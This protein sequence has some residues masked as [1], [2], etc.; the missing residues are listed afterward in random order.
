VPA[1]LVIRAIKREW[2]AGL[3]ARARAQ[4]TDPAFGPDGSLYV[5][6]HAAPFFGGLGSIVRIAPG[7]TRPMVA[8]RDV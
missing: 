5:L 8:R 3:A 4:I 6:Q 2:L 7:G 1:G